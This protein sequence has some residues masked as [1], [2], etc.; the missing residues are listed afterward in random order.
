MSNPKT[1]ARIAA[2]IQERA[3]HCLAHEIKDP[4]AGFV[5][6]TR[7][8]VS[9]DLSHARLFYSVLGSEG[10]RSKVEHMLKSASGFVQRQVAGVLAMRRAP[11]LSW[12]YDD[13]I[14]YQAKVDAAIREAIERD[15]TINPHAH[16][17]VPDAPPAVDEKLVLE[18]EIND[19]LDEQAH[20]DGEEPPPPPRHGGKP[21]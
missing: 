13:S 11:R 10:E 4:R 8:E 17:D 7:V 9:E 12:R 6:I 2:R 21:R 18:S 3:A 14:E 5:T 16:E 1:L 20:E 19:F 15:R